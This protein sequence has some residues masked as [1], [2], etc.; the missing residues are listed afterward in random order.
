MSERPTKSVS[1]A[2]NIFFER[3]LI[4]LPVSGVYHMGE[5]W[6]EMPELTPA[7]VR[8]AVALALWLMT[9]GLYRLL[10]G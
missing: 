5:A 4:Y 1:P 2:V 9:L 8:T 7:I 6:R 10:K 3:G